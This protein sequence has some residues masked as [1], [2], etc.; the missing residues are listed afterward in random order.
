MQKTKETR[1]GWGVL[2]AAFF[3]G[4]FFSQVAINDHRGESAPKFSGSTTQPQIEIQGFAALPSSQ[5]E[6]T[7]A[8][9][10]AAESE[11]AVDAAQPFIAPPEEMADN[12]YYPNWSAARAAGAAPVYADELG[13]SRR[14]DRDGDG[15]GCE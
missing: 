13:Y 3:G 10:I 12:V 15:V 1:F 11:Q 8:P 4:A 2:I 5:G 6:V 14:L 7:A 9:L